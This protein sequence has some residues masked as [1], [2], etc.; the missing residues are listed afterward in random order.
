M[1][2]RSPLRDGGA[3]AKPGRFCLRHARKAYLCPMQIQR[4]T[5]NPLQEN[6][7]VLWCE[8]S[9]ECV[10][11]D[12]GMYERREQEEMR[13]FLSSHNLNPIGL[14]GTHAHIDH[15]FGNQWLLDSYK[16]PYHL[17]PLDIPMIERSKAMAAVW[18]L[19]Y[20]ESPLP[21]FELQHGQVL[22]LGHDEVEVRFV[23][24]HAPG[25]VVF[26]NHSNKWAVVGDTVFSG[27]IGRTDLPGGNHEQ[28]I[29]SIERELFSLADDYQ[30]HPG[31]GPSTTVG[32]EKER[33]PFFEHLR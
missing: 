22:T 7:Y 2:Y 19:N 23:P 29:S 5:F 26:C 11:V 20:H 28:L 9:R 33:N 8:I 14:W 27:S 1:L 10:I 32:H 13:E 6:T 30:L 21:D 24:G 31:H 12:A 18:N 15:I 25:H 17:H 4:F 16:V 3:R